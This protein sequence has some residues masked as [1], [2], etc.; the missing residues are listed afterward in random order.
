M[1]SI[2]RGDVLHSRINKY[3]CNKPAF[4]DLQF[5]IGKDDY[6]FLTHN[7]YINCANLRTVRKILLD[8][9]IATGKTVKVGRLDS[10]II[11]HIL[12]AVKESKVFTKKQIR[13]FFE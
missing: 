5:G 13:S 6:S 2:C 7:S 8:K 9:S 11:D 12:K 3:I 10:E 1:M 4:L